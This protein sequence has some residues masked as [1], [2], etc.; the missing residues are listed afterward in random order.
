MLLEVL[1]KGKVM[2]Y[3]GA[4]I[5]LEVYV[6]EQ[7]NTVVSAEEENIQTPEMSVNEKREH[8][9][10]KRTLGIISVVLF[11]CLM[12]FVAVFIGKPFIEGV[13]GSGEGNAATVFQ[14]IVNENPA[15]AR[16][17]YVVVQ[18]LQ[19]FIA[20][21]PGE[22]VE[23][24]GGLAFGAI[25]GMIL[26]LIGVAIGSSVIF[27]LTKTLGIRFVELFVSRDKINELRFIRNGKNL[28]WI[29]FYVFLIPGT[30]KDLLTYVVGLTRMKL[31]PFLGISLLARVPSVLSSTWGGDAIIN[32]EY[33]KA[34]IIF[35]VAIVCSLIGLLL[36]NIMKKRH[37]GKEKNAG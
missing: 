25:E 14:N 29:V 33:T 13:F 11:F 10:L 18:I 3:N 8:L 4:K 27:M 17:L 19:V 36:Y 1:N 28:E 34:I 30:P 31:L 5:C 24:A 16:L 7:N 9:A 35:S 26:S 6:V 20:L 22:V 12:A 15:K 2:C 37:H 23:I 21:I 32:G